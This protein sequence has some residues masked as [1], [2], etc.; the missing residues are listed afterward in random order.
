M[1]Y[2]EMTF[3]Q[4]RQFLLDIKHRTENHVRDMLVRNIVGY[5]ENINERKEDDY[6]STDMLFHGKDIYG[7]D[8][9][10]GGC[11]EVN[12]HVPMPKIVMSADTGN[13]WSF[14]LALRYTVNPDELDAVN[15]FVEA[16][17]FTLIEYT[18]EERASLDARAQFYRKISLSWVEYVT[19]CPRWDQRDVLMTNH[20]YL[21]QSYIHQTVFPDKANLEL[22]SDMELFP[23]ANAGEL[24]E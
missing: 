3:D 19:E 6:F 15:Y 14:D 18:P 12:V 17:L 4:A 23:L 10:F 24:H 5:K 22:D 7:I 13:L 11:M 21:V 8:L 1:N 9:Y 2:K 20:F 16:F